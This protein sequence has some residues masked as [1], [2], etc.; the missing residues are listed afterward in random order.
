MS[1][2]TLFIVYLVYGLAFF[3]MGLILIL[4]ASRT[5]TPEQK[6]LLL[7]LSV[8]GFLHGIHEWLEFFILQNEQLH[9]S[10]AVWVT[11][12]RLLLLALSYVMLWLYGWQS[13]QVARKHFSPFTFFGLITLPP[14]WS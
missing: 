6:Q 1:F 7:P 14:H 10:L 5:P 11:W 8:F 2:E 3:S 12:F 9:G 13:F 4:E